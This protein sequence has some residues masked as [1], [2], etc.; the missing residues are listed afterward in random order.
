MTLKKVRLRYSKRFFKS[1]W[2]AAVKPKGMSKKQKIKTEQV[3]K[4]K[5][6]GDEL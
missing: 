5:K 3:D 6:S 2:T 4:K 1:R